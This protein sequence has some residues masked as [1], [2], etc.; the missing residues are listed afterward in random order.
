MDS[1]CGLLSKN[2]RQKRFRFYPVLRDA[3]YCPDAMAA[4]PH[5]LR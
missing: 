5:A 1:T 2:G 4:Q 3:Q